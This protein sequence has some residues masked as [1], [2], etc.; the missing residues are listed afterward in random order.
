[1][2]SLEKFIAPVGEIS[3]VENLCKH[4][5]KCLGFGRG[6]QIAGSFEKLHELRIDCT[7]Q[8]G[9]VLENADFQSVERLHI[10]YYYDGKTP[11]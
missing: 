7:Y 8:D 1:M 4:R 2:T 11:K 9:L 3:L 6:N 5:L 10:N